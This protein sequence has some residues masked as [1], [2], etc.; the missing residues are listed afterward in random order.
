[1]QATTNGLKSTVRTP[2][3]TLLFILI[4]TVTA[5]L[6]T[7]SCCVFD[8]VR[9]YL[10]DCDDFFHTIAELEY[11]GPN[12]PDQVIYDESLAQAVEKNRDALS[13]L[14]SVEPVLSWEPASTEL[15]LSPQIR[16]WDENVPDPYVAVLRVRL[17]AYEED[18][19]LYTALVNESYYSRRDNTGKLIMV[20]GVDGAPRLEFNKDYLMVG[21]FFLSYSGFSSFQIAAASYRDDGKLVELPPLLPEG[22]SPEEEAPF[23]RYAELLHLKN[24]ACRVSYTS[25]I[26]DLY[27]F[28][29]Q[30]MTLT[31]GRFFTQAE[32]DADAKVCIISER[33]AGML[34]LKVGDRLPFTLYRAEGDLYEPANL[35]QLDDDAYEI[36]GIISHSD[37]YPFWTFLPRARTSNEIHPVNGYTLGQFRLKNDGVSAFLEAAAPLLE[38]GFRLNV[39]DQGYAAATEP[40]EELLF[41]SRIFLA[42]CLLLA[43]CALAMQSH[44]FI[45][46]QRETARTMYALGSGRA[47]VCVYFLAAALALTIP[48]AALGAFIGSQTEGWVF[49][50]LQRFAAQFADQDLRFSAT[51]LAI[52]RT[53]DFNPDASLRAYLTAAGLLAGG[54]L[55]FTLLFALA[56]LREKKTSK[57]KDR[58]QRVPKRGARVS[59]LS[60]FFKY[61]LLSLCRGR[62]RTAV[63]LLLGLS[64]ALFFGR[65]TASLRGY[66]EQLD[67]YRANAVIS[68]NATD[69]YGKRISGLTLQG[70][71]VSRISTDELLEDFCATTNLGHIKFLG[72]VGGEQLPFDMPQSSYAYETVFFLLNKE[73]LWVGTSSIT[74]SPQFH[75]SDSG[76]VEW[77]EGWSEADFVRL[78]EKEYQSYDVYLEA[79]FPKKYMGGPEICAL[80]ASMMEKYGIQL[81]D[82]INTIVA[83]YY[84]SSDYEVLALQELLV[85][86]SYTAP[87]TSTAI[88][89][90]VTFVHPYEEDL[91]YFSVL[92]EAGPKEFWI[93][94]EKWKQEELAGLQALGLSPA[95]NYASYTF[96]L[97]DSARLDELREALAEAG[98]TWV[99]SGARTKPFAMIED[100]VYLNTVHSMERQIQYVGVLYTALYILA[101]IIGS[102]LAWLL[103]LSRRREIAVMRALGTQPGRILGN[104]LLEQLLLMAAA[105]GLGI[106]VCRLTGAALN[107]TQL[108]LTGAFLA[109][110]TLSTLICLIVGLRKKS[111]AALT[112]PE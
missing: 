70:S 20:R 110:W 34:E 61:G 57:K 42:V 10:D 50:I 29:Q 98:F 38:Q 84:D 4:L 67:A 83:Y 93:G 82:S 71:A 43:V 27:P 37:S 30:L 108:L 74:R 51:R 107:A 18:K 78:E 66:E 104:F 22:A 109:V 28:H 72:V 68:G 8:A 73:P 77:L 64:A 47:H 48:A 79:W 11:M 13:A 99:H 106:G 44:I 49:G 86:A 39:Y 46:R 31:D 111:F 35:V 40:M 112:E 14:I 24:D 92:D 56:S 9:S 81:G 100:E 26:E 75:F 33:I 25:A 76:S 102:A 1:M 55:V 23:L 63:V 58:K 3:K 90:P 45:S 7:V 69:Y 91:H 15:M 59:R 36:V 41:I 53:L 12:Y 60:G 87:V 54:T 101:G 80:P 97:K 2:G 5:A 32:Y 85:V 95:L 103:I 62:G 89:S 94:R 105:L 6:L 21:N 19:G 88:F 17:Y 65:L 52:T 16:R 96:T